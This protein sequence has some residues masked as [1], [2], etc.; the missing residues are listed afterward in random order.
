[1]DSKIVTMTI[2]EQ[3]KRERSTKQKKNEAHKKDEQGRKGKS[4]ATARREKE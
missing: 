2:A 3:E 1:M 4:L